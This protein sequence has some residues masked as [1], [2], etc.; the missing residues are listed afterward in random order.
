MRI[1]IVRNTHGQYTFEVDGERYH[2]SWPTLQLARRAALK[3]QPAPKSA[4]PKKEI[5]GNADV[6]EV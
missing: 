3:Y 1:E 4:K 2:D 6:P 5:T